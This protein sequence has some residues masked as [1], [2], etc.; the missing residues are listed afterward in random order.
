MSS[1]LE[2]TLYKPDVIILGIFGYSNKI[3]EDDLR[4]NGLML[5][6]QE[7]GKIPNKILL[8]SDG[9]SSIYIQ[10]WA[11]SLH[12]NTQIFRADWMKHGRIAQI[13]RDDRIEKE[14]T[15]AFVIL[16]EK[17]TRLE[18]ISEKLAKKGKIVF[19]LSHNQ[20]LTQLELSSPVSSS[21]VSKNARKSSKGTMLK[22]LKYQTKE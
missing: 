14:C 17:S 15:H 21:Q 20:I 13:I 3:S 19:T 7:I 18:K 5:I 16:S 2:D 8:H 4:D 11:E 9:N 1:V 12:I 6:L 22:W 10:E